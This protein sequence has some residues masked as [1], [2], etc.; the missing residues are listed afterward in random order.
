M[1]I[2]QEGI[3]RTIARKG[4]SGQPIEGAVIRLQG[5]HNKVASRENGDFSLL[6]HD[7]QNGEAYAFASIYK[8][9]YEPAEQELI[10]KRLP[11]SDQVPDL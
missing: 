6:L 3:V 7:L 8:S 1:A 5:S 9:G 4:Q 10:G 11:C 2:T